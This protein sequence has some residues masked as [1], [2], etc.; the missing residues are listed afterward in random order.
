MF[1]LRRGTPGCV[2]RV[3][4]Y[5]WVRPGYTE[6]H[7]APWLQV[8]AD[9]GDTRVRGDTPIPGMGTREIYWVGLMGGFQI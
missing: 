4:R 1:G 7:G 6:P 8:Y 9:P 2:V 5:A 3:C